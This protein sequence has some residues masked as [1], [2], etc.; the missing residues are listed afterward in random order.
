LLCS[1]QDIPS[2]DPPSAITADDDP[3]TWHVQ[4]FRSIDAGSCCCLPES[5]DI[6][7]HF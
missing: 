7:I 2:I 6:P 5:L 1:L 3:D 4:F